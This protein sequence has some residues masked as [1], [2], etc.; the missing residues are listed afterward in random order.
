MSTR[1]LIDARHSEET[2]VTVVRGSRVEEFDYESASRRQLKG[3]IYLARVTRVEPSLQAAFVEY[4]GNRHGFLAFSEIHPDYYQIPVEDREAL[5]QA[6]ADAL[7]SEDEDADDGDLVSDG[8]EDGDGPAAA[9]A[10][11]PADSDPADSD[12]DTDADS[13]DDGD[14]AS[15][16]EDGDQDVAA[17]AA[18]RRRALRAIKRKYSIQEV[19]KKRQVLLVQV[20]K[21]ERGNKG[22]AL[23]TYLSLAGRYCVLMPNSTNTGGISRKISSA[24]D[25]RKLKTIISALEVPSDMGLIVRTA[26]MNRTKTEIK[27]DY[28]YLVRLWSDIRDLTLQSMAPCR[29]YE[30]A[31]LIRRTIRDLYSR[32]MDEILVEG[33]QGYRA[34]KD[35]M[36][37]LVPSHAKKVKHYKDKIPL[38]HRYQVEGQLESMYQPVVNLRSGGYLVINPTEALIS[39]DVN[40]GRSTREHNI[41]GTAV[42]TNL[43]AAEEVA[44]QLKLRDMAGLVVIDFIDME[45]RNNLRSVER[46]M[47]DVLKT[48]RA[49]VQ[50]G[51]I[52]GFGLM[53]MSRQRLRPNLIEASMTTCPH[54]QGTGLVRSVDSAS[55]LILRQLEEEGIRARSQSV[56]VAANADVAAFL[57]NVKR[58]QLIELEEK[59]S[60]RIEVIAKFDIG[61][62]EFEI[63]R[64]PLGAEEDAAPEVVTMAQPAA[65]PEPA[66]QPQSQSQSSRN[67]RHDDDGDEDERG[68]RKRRRRRRRKG[69]GDGEDSDVQHSQE[70]EDHPQS[71]TD[72]DAEDEEKRPRRRRGRRGG[73]RRRQETGNLEDG[74]AASASAKDSAADTQSGAA[75]PSS[76]DDG[77]ITDAQEEEKPRR[78]RRRATPKSEDTVGDNPLAEGGDTPATTDP[79]PVADAKPAVTRRRRTKAADA[80]SS[81]T[82]AAADPDQADAGTSG[83]VKADDVKADDTPK[84]KRRRTKKADSAESTEPGTGPA[85]TDEKVAE[86]D[87][88]KRRR[89]TRKKADDD[90]EADSA[91]KPAA[92]GKAPARTRTKAAKSS[93]TPD[94]APEAPSTAPQAAPADVTPSEAKPA[95]PPAPAA[96]AP[97]PDTANAVPADHTSAAPDD[98]RPKRK[99]WWQRT[100]G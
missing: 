48:D 70:R 35:F 67:T 95:Q 34:A 85:A 5:L 9:D 43:E 68:Q 69:R 32:E 60:V 26:G 65:A 83:D 51:R 10:D 8:A 3:N 15:G 2:R 36:K 99:G 16:D 61:Q 29:V 37:L 91:K 58:P 27:R 77:N 97:E 59:Y 75:A 24:T 64:I 80:D 11:D 56:R 66:P 33:E 46:R 73:R 93:D 17:A 82:P 88:P 18:T 86:E 4:G 100:F 42:K 14:T 41:E 87:K 30:E 62:S 45:D 96:T 22:A 57:L 20:V 12:I 71:D 13:D 55:L 78:R 21:E 81:D 40:S 39:V 54:C 74:V 98:D 1:M 47:K 84:P 38:F 63:T 76:A 79:A 28:E 52:S 53:E 50:L 49:R 6:E 31:D 90:G 94:T 72:S 23:T 92:K 19:I 89:T 44:R 25:R 7:T